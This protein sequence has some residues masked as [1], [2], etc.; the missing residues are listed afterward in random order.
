MATGFFNVPVPINEPV[1]GYAPGSKE[2][3]ELQQELKR[4][5]GLELDIPMHI[6]GEQVRTGDLRGKA[7]TAEFTRALVAR[8]TNG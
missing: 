7:T 2:K 8:I 6:G 1:K 5:R 3:L 4:L